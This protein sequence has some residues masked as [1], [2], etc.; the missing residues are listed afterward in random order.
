MADIFDEMTSSGDVFD[1]LEEKSPVK[2]KIQSAVSSIPGQAALG[3]LKRFTW[4]AD[5]YKLLSQGAAMEQLAQFKEQAIEEGDTLFN[6]EMAR[7]SMMKAFESFPTQELA[8][9]KLEEATGINFSPEGKYQ[10]IARG[11]GELFSFRPTNLAQ[12]GATAIAKRLAR[13]VGGS[14]A[15]AS[16]EK[17]L[18]ET[19][20]P[21]PVA[22]LA[23]GATHGIAA[24]GKVA[25][26]TLKTEAAKEAREIAEK[27][28]LR[29]FSGIEKESTTRFKP[30]I[31]QGREE[32]LREELAKTS[33]EAI[34]KVVEE[35]IPIKKL[36]DKGYDLKEAYTES[37]D[38]ARKAASKEKTPVNIS[39]I[40]R[41]IEK[42]AARIRT[43]A[44]SRSD[45]DRAALKILK[46]EHKALAYANPTPDELLNQ[47][48]NWNKNLKGI[49]RKPEFAGS[50]SEVARIYGELKNQ[51]IKSLEKTGRKEVVEPFK[52]ANKLYHERAKLDEVE[53]I[54][55]KALSE[56]YDP[57]K[58]AK[59]LD[60]KRA[61]GFLKRDIGKEGVQELK[62][63]AKYGKIAEEKVF[64][65]LK[66][67]SKTFESLAK[68]I[69]VIGAL[70]IKA[71]SL[72]LA[73][74]KIAP[75]AINR[76]RGYLFTRDST[77]KNYLNFLKSAAEGNPALIKREA[78]KLNKSIA[79]EFGSVE[80]IFS[81]VEKDMNEP[82]E[83]E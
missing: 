29:K 44:P 12:K 65:N 6:E 34:E 50:E 13:R 73:P 45:P 1:S 36:R 66:I 11:A 23:G 62:D 5:L 24:S 19:G 64:D 78:E 2:E 51:L 68:E 63:I 79:D 7:E 27:H 8:E 35:N 49:Y 83:K 57:K 48:Q 82:E 22:A 16:T 52:F 69:G 60:S 74:F 75:A 46:R 21:K 47:Y 3:L 55:E 72:P 41:W 77:R 30:T 17:F 54:L 81:L 43:A 32:K 56:K 37:F 33:K 15:G 14:I 59:L 67:P 61:G 80:D 4:P 10:D 76:V 70:L 26:K 20:V 25:P 18:E 9:K 71:K 39:N 58:L 40:S 28:N 42:E 31:T 38:L 53:D